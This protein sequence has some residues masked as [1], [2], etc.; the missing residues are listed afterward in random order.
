M[1][2]DKEIAKIGDGIRGKWVFDKKKS[3]LMPMKEKKKEVVAAPFVIGD[4]MP[5]IESMAT[6]EGLKFTSRS[7]YRQHL[8]EHGMRIRE[9][10]ENQTPKYIRATREEIRDTAE[11][12]YMDLKYGRVP[13]SEKEK[14][15][16]L[17]E[18]RE[19]EAYKKRQR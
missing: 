4:E 8:K 13:L 15:R 12:A 17:R 9:K 11:K 1:A 14:E 16:C 6:D 10:G 7:R 5:E 2:K 19:W 18:E 3:K